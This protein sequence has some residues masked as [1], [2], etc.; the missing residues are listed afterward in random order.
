MII[1]MHLHL[2]GPG[3]PHYRDSGLEILCEEC[4]KAGV[5]RVCIS[6]CGRQYK[7]PGNEAVREAFTKYPDFLIGFAYVRLGIDRPWV[8]DE[9]KAQGFGGIKVI[10]PLDDYMR[11]Y[12]RAARHKLPILFHTGTVGS[13]GLDHEYDVSSDRMRPIKLDRIARTFPELPLI[14][15][16]LGVP[17]IDEAAS[18]MCGHPNVYFDMSGGPA[19]HVGS[20]R[21][22]DTHTLFFWG[23]LHRQRKLG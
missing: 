12:E 20:P 10:S 18:L 14:G 7:Q 8:V 19:A 11:L 21:F 15:A 13:L 22:R 17:W 6:S 5:D 4:A 23:L 3:H 2:F 16:H 1:D 9:I